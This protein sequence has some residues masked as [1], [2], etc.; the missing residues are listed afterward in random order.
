MLSRNDRMAVRSRNM[1]ADARAQTPSADNREQL[2]LRSH[3]DGVLRLTL[4]SP[5]NR[6]ALSQAMMG[7]L[8]SAL[9]AAA[10][11]GETR[12]IVIAGNGPAFCAG[13]DLRELDGARSAPDRGRAFFARLMAQCA[14][15]MQSIVNHPRPVIA[16]VRGIATAAGCQLVASCDLAVASGNSRFATPGVQIGLFCS[17]PMVALSRNVSRKHAMEMLLT[18]DM[19]DAQRAQEIGLVNRVVDEAQMDAAVGELARKIAGRSLM[20]LKTGKQAF[21][22]QADMDLAQAY[23]HTVDVMIDNML[24]AD[25]VEGV[26]AFLQKRQPQWRDE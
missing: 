22:Q 8:Q 6:N 26:S 19:I 12:V 25:A 15:L 23:A 5:S 4:N 3:V 24:K 11:D 13:H 21:Y 20:T 16:D 2:V 14:A 9:D 18:G 10:S 17:T 7:A 1:Q